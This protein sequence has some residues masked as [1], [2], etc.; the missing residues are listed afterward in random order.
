MPSFPFLAGFLFS[1]ANIVAAAYLKDKYHVPSVQF[2]VCYLVPLLW[3]P[4]W[5]LLSSVWLF[6]SPVWPLFRS[7]FGS[8]TCPLNR[9][10]TIH[11][12]LH[13]FVSGLC[14]LHGVTHRCLQ[15]CCLSKLGAL[16]P[17]WQNLY[18]LILFLLILFDFGWANKEVY[19]RHHGS[20]SQSKN[21]G[22]SPSSK[23]STGPSRRCYPRTCPNRSNRRHLSHKHDVPVAGER[24]RQ[25]KMKV[26]KKKAK[27]K[28][29]G[30]VSWGGTRQ[31]K[32][33]QGPLR[34]SGWKTSYEPGLRQRKGRR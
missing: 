26:K 9:Q 5:P 13:L 14:T 24:T 18:L 32:S 31:I 17:V 19:I 1:P 4:V 8:R 23:N 12:L 33:Q 34:D 3:S 6:L 22:R 16:L 15:A 10:F 29:E 28:R 20:W 2:V 21:G 25:E 7:P 11:S 27:K 30:L